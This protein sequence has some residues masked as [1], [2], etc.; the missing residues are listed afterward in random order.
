MYQ[1][2]LITAAAKKAL[3][4]WAE[5]SYIPQRFEARVEFRF[6]PEKKLFGTRVHTAKDVPEWYEHCSRKGLQDIM[7][8]I[9]ISVDDLGSLGFSSPTEGSIVCFYDGAKATSFSSRWEPDPAGKM[10]NAYYSEHEWACAAAK[11]PHFEDDTDSFRSVLY[12]IREFASLIGFDEFAATFDN[13][14]SILSGSPSFKES[15]YDVPLPELPEYNLQI[16]KAAI[17]ADVFGAMGSWNDSP[18]FIA[19]EKGLHSQYESLSRELLRQVRL[20]LLYAIN[21]W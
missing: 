2:C 5:F 11:K 19:R 6:L 7:M 8:T 20:A 16:F 12:Q 1:I 21:G 3:Q 18:T 10:W 15:I 13:A 17:T 4:G 9:P 14:L